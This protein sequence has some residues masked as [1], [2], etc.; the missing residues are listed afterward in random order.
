[1]EERLLLRAEEVAELLGVG[2]SK[3]WGMIWARQLPIVRMGRAV[4]VPRRELDE[5]VRE[6]TV[7]G[8]SSATQ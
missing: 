2:R 8:R 5:W 7:A 1:M 3:V 4:R 6:R